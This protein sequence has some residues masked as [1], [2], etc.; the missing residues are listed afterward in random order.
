VKLQSVAKPSEHGGTVLK[1]KNLL[2]GHFK[3]CRAV[4]VGISS[5][6]ST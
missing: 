5:K 3:S 6:N 1:A 2:Y 4:S